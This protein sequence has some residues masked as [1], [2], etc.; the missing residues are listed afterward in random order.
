MLYPVPVHIPR[1]NNFV[2]GNRFCKL[3]NLSMFQT[4]YNYDP[5]LTA[6]WGY[7]LK[8]MLENYRNL[9]HVKLFSDV[10]SGAF[11]E[12]IYYR[13]MDVIKTIMTSLSELDDDGSGRPPALGNSTAPNFFSSSGILTVD[14][15]EV[16]IRKAFPLKID[17]SVESLVLAAQTELEM[18]SDSSD[19]INFQVSWHLQQLLDSRPN[20]S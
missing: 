6:E 13:E 17:R 7:S 11:S 18:V 8:Q 9:P 10:L 15:F 3:Q 14:H 4:R 16:G 1:Y 12:E 19:S 20:L 2:A 5:E